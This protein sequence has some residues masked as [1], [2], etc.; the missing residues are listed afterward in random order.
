[1]PADPTASFRARILSEAGLTLPVDY[2][3]ERR[4]P[5]GARRQAFLEL[6][7]RRNRVWQTDFFELKTSGGAT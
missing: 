7:T 5:A 6:P 4:D 1:M 2:V 3:R